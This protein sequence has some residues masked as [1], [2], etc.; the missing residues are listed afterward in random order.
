[1]S[2]YV[3]NVPLVGQKTGHDGRPLMQPG[4][5]G[6]LVPH[7]FMAC[8]YAAA[9]MVS[10]YFAPGPRLG[11]PRVWAADRGLSVAAIHELARIEGLKTVPKPAS[12]LTVDVVAKL[13]QAHGPIWAAGRYLDGYPQAGHAVVLTGVKGEHILYNDPWEPRAKMRH[14][15]WI[16]SRLLGLSNAMLVKDRTRS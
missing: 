4:P 16:D 11:L 5:G 15:T 13:L 7:G 12:G 10:Y 3:L 14:W 2:D 8:W 9:C 1:M 6:A